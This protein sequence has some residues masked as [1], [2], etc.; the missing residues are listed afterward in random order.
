MNTNECFYNEIKKITIVFLVMA[1]I[2]QLFFISTSATKINQSVDKIPD[3]ILQED[4]EEAN[5]YIRNKEQEV[6][7]NSIC[8]FDTKSN[9]SVIRIYEDP[10]K[11]IDTD[12]IIKDKNISL[13][14]N[15]ILSE[16]EYS[17]VDNDVKQFY[18]RVLSNN[19][20]IEYNQYS[21]EITPFYGNNAKVEK[22]VDSNYVYYKEAF[23]NNTVLKYTPLLNGVK[24]D[25]I[26][27][28]ENDVN[29]Y[30]FIIKT[31]NI[32]IKKIG[33]QVCGINID[34]NTILEIGDIVIYDNTNKC[35]KGDINV[36]QIDNAKNNEFIISLSLP[37]EMLLDDIVYPVTIDPTYTF[38]SSTSS[39]YELDCV[40]GIVSK[41]N[42]LQTM[43]DGVISN[44]TERRIVFNIPNLSFYI[45]QFIIPLN[46]IYDIKC[47]FYNVSQNAGSSG[48]K[49]RAYALTT[50]L[51]SSAI[52]LWNSYIT[53]NFLQF[54]MGNSAGSYKTVS[55]LS[56]FNASETIRN[57]ILNN[58]I[59]LLS[60]NSS[61]YYATINSPASSVN[62]PYYTVTYKY[63]VSNSQINGISS[64]YKYT[65]INNN[66]NK[67]IYG[68]D[69][70]VAL[71]SNTPGA[72]SDFS[73]YYN[74]SAGG[75][76]IRH[77][78]G[79]YL[80]AESDKTI[81]LAD[82]SNSID[83]KWYLI[84]N[85]NKYIIVS[86]RFQA[87]ALGYN[88]NNTST[89]ILS[90]ATSYTN[91]LWNLNIRK[92]TWFSQHRS[93]DSNGVYWNNAYLNNLY[94]INSNSGKAFFDN[95]L[96]D[97]VYNDLMC[98]GCYVTSIAMVLRNMNATTTGYDFRKT[99]VATGASTTLEADP[100]IVVLANCRT[101][102]S[103]A[104]ISNT[105]SYYYINNAPSDITNAY[106]DNIG[107]SF[108]VTIS[109]AINL[110]GS[111]AA[112][113]NVIVQALAN[114]P[115]GILLRFQSGSNVHTVVAMLDP[116]NSND[117]VIYDSAHIT[118]NAG[119]G[120][121][122]GSTC[123]LFTQSLTNATYYQTITANN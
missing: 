90:D 46:M 32:V 65:I 113:K 57:N 28:S 9:E 102:S 64:G 7:L 109:N 67:F 40:N 68:D 111:N 122:I 23:G 92:Y 56:L 20:K 27:Y 30:D 84:S 82:E 18:P 43:N 98:D 55:I 53:T 58:G 123:C 76:K 89:L 119:A 94:R 74:Y 86:A 54:S 60:Y 39:M 99:G 44:S 100:F 80:T 108:G 48:T 103:I 51:Q 87:Y 114:N 83:Q 97:G 2:M 24:E 78:N 120:V 61:P 96:T 50:G 70:A 25:I 85:Q 42:S 105:G 17:I 59:A 93:N 35:F 33:D 62:K 104:T 26:L 116:N 29:R 52:D 118:Y 31:N 6:D 66:T 8:Y 38:N 88:Q 49:I 73:F 4:G 12:G 1:L 10:V 107:L 95:T 121:P 11:Y 3:F 101:D 81:T 19:V 72:F 34:G 41:T 21:I 115:Q 47:N 77:I 69:T 45:N 117:F 63:N 106:F 71:S 16:Y 15:S 110:S 36:T 91:L 22:F 75:Y 13:Q 79:K 37:D 5:N 14:K 112:K